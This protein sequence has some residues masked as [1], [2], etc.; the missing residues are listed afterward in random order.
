M[1]AVFAT[2]SAIFD[3]AQKNKKWT[4]LENVLLCRNYTINSI[5]EYAFLLH[6]KWSFFLK[7]YI[8]HLI[9]LADNYKFVL[10]N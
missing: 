4:I 9:K 10:I 3:N 8:T 1:D 5:A 2:L 7:I 6:K